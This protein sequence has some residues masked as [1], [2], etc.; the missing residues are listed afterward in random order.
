MISYGLGLARSTTHHDNDFLLI[1]YKPV[2]GK[3]VTTQF[4][5]TLP[6]WHVALWYAFLSIRRSTHGGRMLWP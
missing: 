2:N 1:F 4:V 3:R 6:T 5:M